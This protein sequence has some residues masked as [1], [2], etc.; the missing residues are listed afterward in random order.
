MWFIQ[1]INV[2]SS[3]DS[4]FISLSLFLVVSVSSFLMGAKLCCL[5]PC[6]DSY[7]GEWK[8]GRKHGRGTYHWKTGECYTG[9]WQSNARHGKGINRWSNGAQYEGEWQY[10]KQHGTGT[11]KAPPSSLA[12]S[13]ASSTNQSINQLIPIPVAS[14]LVSYTGSWAVGLKHGEGLA[15]Y[16]DGTVYHGSWNGDKMHGQGELVSKD[17]SSY[18]GS[19]VADRFSG[20]GVC[21]RS[22]DVFEGEFSNNLMNGDGRW[23]KLNGEQ[24]TGQF[25]RG[26]LTGVVSIV[27]TGS[28]EVYQGEILNGDKHGF[29]TIIYS[30]GESLSCHFQNGQPVD[31]SGNVSQTIFGRYQYFDG[32][33]YEGNMISNNQVVPQ[34]LSSSVKT[35]LSDQPG[36]V[37][38]LTSSSSS[39]LVV[40]PFHRHGEGELRCADGSFYRGEFNHD[41]RSGFGHQLFV[42][43][44]EYEGDWINDKRCGR[45]WFI[46]CDPVE[47]RYEGEWRDNE[48]HGKGKLFYPLT[49]STSR[50]TRTISLIQSNATDPGL[51]VNVVDDEDEDV[52]CSRFVDNKPIDVSDNIR[53][54]P[55]RM[56]QARIMELEEQLQASKDLM[57]L[58]DPATCCRA[59]RNQK[60]D[61]LIL[62]CAHMVLCSSCASSN[63]ERC[64][65]CNAK[66]RKFVTVI[67][68]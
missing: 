5:V 51:T 12:H 6:A 17:G 21:E 63:P 39:E 22:G 50:T 54:A 34:S 60:A 32:S 61:C 37:D 55:F 20:H 47:P 8:S 16:E 27:K 31:A 35:V 49:G 15:V 59:C 64:P 41:F 57:S 29:G 26:V 18:V 36:E 65:K 44:S 56:L 9:D 14:S 48:R 10:N 67:E 1:S 40:C 66:A 45:G 23:A 68:A 33:V 4:I 38:H 43:G 11:Y 13:S 30:N 52:F 24:I 58:V 62:D 53:V 28:N 25:V 3:F 2:I 7:N 42:D 46:S 19:F